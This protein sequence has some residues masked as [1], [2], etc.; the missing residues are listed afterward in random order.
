MGDGA[1][2]LLCR[3]YL[4]LLMFLLRVGRKK[5]SGAQERSDVKGLHGNRIFDMYTRTH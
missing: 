2:D 5:A 4:L 3:L 1:V